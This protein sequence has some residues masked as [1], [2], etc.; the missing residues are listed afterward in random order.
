MWPCA[1][2]DTAPVTL[3]W[4]GYL[5]VTFEVDGGGGIKLPHLKLVRITLET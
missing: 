5:G 2:T 1:T 3:I 4:V